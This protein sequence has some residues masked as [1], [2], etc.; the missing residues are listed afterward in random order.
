[1]RLPHVRRTP[2]SPRFIASQLPRHERDGQSSDA[3]PP[4]RLD[5]P[6][7][8][9]STPGGRTLATL[10]LHESDVLAFTSRSDDRVVTHLLHPIG[11][12]LPPGFLPVQYSGTLY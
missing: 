11:Y 7:A 8:D 3:P 6:S 12:L 10:A 4:S 1:V 2:L 5:E 9:D